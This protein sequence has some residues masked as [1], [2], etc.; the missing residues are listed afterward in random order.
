MN[1]LFIW[2]SEVYRSPERQVRKNTYRNF[3][4]TLFPRVCVHASV[5]ETY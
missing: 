4:H 3:S 2:L 1:I 5:S